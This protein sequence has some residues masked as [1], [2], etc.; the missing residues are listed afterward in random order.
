M[1]VQALAQYADHY[2]AEELSNAAWETKPVPWQINI[3][4]LGKLSSLTERR[5]TD[6]S[7]KKPRQVAMPM[8][9]P[10]SPVNRNSGEHPLLGADDIAYVLGVGPWTP[11]KPSDKEKAEKHHA[12]FVELIGKAAQETGDDALASCVRFYE[13]TEE[14][15]NARAALG[16]A[17]AGDL[18]VLAVGIGEMLVAREAVSA[19]WDAHYKKEYETERVK[20]T[21][22]ECIIS[23]DFGPI[24]LT[25]EKVKGLPSAQIKARVEV[26]LMA[27]DKDAFCSYGW[28]QNR[29]SPVSPD[30]ALA[31]VLALN[32]LLRSK[33]Q[34]RDRS[35]IAYLYWLKGPGDLDVQDMLERADP[36]QVRDL[37][38]MKPEAAAENRPDPN[39]FYMIGVSGNGGRLRVRYWVDRTVADVKA[40]LRNWFEQLRVEY[41]LNQAEQ[42]A[43]V[44]FWQVLNALDSDGEPK[45]EIT[46][47]LTRRAIEG[48]PLGYS[49]LAKALTKLRHPGESGNAKKASAKQNGPMS[50]SRLRVPMSLIRT[51]L[52]DLQRQKKGVYEVTEGLDPQCAFPAYVCGRLMA[53]FENLQ[54]A[55]SGGEVNSSIVDRYF[56]L[57]STYPAVA[58]P[59]VEALA[60]KHLRKLR[61]DNRGA[62]I[63]IDARLQDLHGLLTPS[64]AGAYPSKLSIEEQGLFAL[65][66]YHQKARSRAE[67]IS[68]QSANAAQ[69]AEN[70]ST[71]EEN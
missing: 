39:R 51:C 49:V 62:A 29:N 70:E 9:V 18:V 37:L 43:P 15:K 61:R 19:F 7:G 36:E 48:T 69:A 3:S 67:A 26:G 28:E 11:D 52:N 14:V 32:D 20:G 53:E 5:T 4:K 8:R 45:S 66:Y 57:A 44:R 64:P 12:A 25:H 63:A 10:R 2:L 41:P 54:R 50:L 42:A 33:T 56:A 16:E 71:E 22:G 47:A 68:K 31:Y 23:G 55:A 58:F 27:F 21:T 65:A 30:R 1:L 46:L 24:A 17:K 40:N 38:D 13:S 59:K 35:G 34:R 60:L 6:T